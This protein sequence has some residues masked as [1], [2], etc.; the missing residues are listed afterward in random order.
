VAR[1]VIS[2]PKR[3]TAFEPIYEC[4]PNIGVSLEVFFADHVLA[5]SFGANSGWFWWRCKS[6]CLPDMPPTGPFGS[7]YTAYRDAL[8]GGKTLFVKEPLY[9]QSA[10]RV[11]QNTWPGR[12]SSW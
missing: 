7:R 5:K 11:G 4:D 6:G 8:D 9:E 2:D 12:T 1:A 10:A 3:R